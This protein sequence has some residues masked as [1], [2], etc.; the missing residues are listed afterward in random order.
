MRL[1]QRPPRI[2][3]A[4]LNA[5]MLRL[6]GEVADGVL[7]NYSPPYAIAPMAA[8]I[9]L[10]A[11]K[12]GRKFTD[13]DVGIYIRICI[14][15]DEDQAVQAFKRELASYAFVDSYNKM[16]ARYGLA[17]ELAEV[18][19]LWGEGKREQAPAAISDVSARKIAL[20]GS[21]KGGRDFVDRFRAAGVTNP[22][23]FPIGPPATHARDF[24]ATMRALAGA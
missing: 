9:R 17:D 8:E 20:F 16:F 14:T 23:V 12:V 6:A 7:M 5:P 19:R 22:V 15:P 11:E 4:A 3:L 18:R 10:G 2:Y 13:L 21:D 24:P 1:T